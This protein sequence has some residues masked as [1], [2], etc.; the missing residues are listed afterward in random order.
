MTR[1]RDSLAKGR[2]RVFLVGAGPGDPGLITVR[3]IECIRQ[4]DLILY[5]YLVNPRLLDHAPPA[6][7]RVCLGRHGQGRI[8]TQE[9]INRRLVDEA[10]RGRIVVRLKGGDPALFARGAEEAQ[11]AANAG[12]PFEI[13]PGITAATAAGSYAGIAVTDRELASAVAF[14]TGQE[15]HG[16][17][18]SQLDITALA[19]FPGT[20]V[21]YMG[22]TTAPRWTQALIAAGKPVD[23]P[24]AIVRRCTWY[25]QRVI[26]CRLVD[27]PQIVADAPMRPP[28]IV[29]IGQVAAR[30]RTTDWFTAR[31]LSGQ[32]VLVTRSRGQAPLLRDALAELG[33]RVLVQSAIDISDPPNWQPVDDAIAQLGR[34][35]WLVFSSA[36]GVRYFLGRL[37]S[38]GRDLRALGGVKLAAIGPGTGQALQDSQLR[39][40][41]Q[42]NQFRSEALADAL[43]KGAGGKRFLLVRASRGR[44]VLPRRLAAAGAD[45]EQVV[46]YTSSD[47]R[48]ASAEVSDALRQGEIGWTTVTS[49]AIAR[50]LA[51]LFG[52]D[53]AKTRL[54]TISPLTSA[55]LRAVGHAPAA[56]ATYYT[57][58]GVVAAILAAVAAG[59]TPGPGRSD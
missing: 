6:A 55:A 51:S 31:P 53:L 29:I 43:A 34:Y 16:K 8:M 12:I 27:V 17:E 10:G 26:H 11:V 22:V 39:A 37:L 18:D 5:D 19:G 21:F 15:W 56:E 44:D 9:E 50:S 35:D 30:E 20:L 47:V 46:A 2:G 23:T 45:V 32:T 59:R 14:V 54:V 38:T 40:D 52:S 49:S 28:V 4:A 24:A 13:V 25:D 42:P 41:V 33:A 7:E 1:V 48:A 58:G 3:G 36:N 57:I